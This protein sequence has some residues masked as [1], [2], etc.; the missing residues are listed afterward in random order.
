MDILENSLANGGGR[1]ER[2]FEGREVRRRGRE[3]FCDDLRAGCT[4]ITDFSF[5]ALRERRRDFF[6]LERL[7][8]F[9]AEAK[10]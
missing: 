6:E 9:I 7:L 3:D 2:D 8:L 10:N 4:T 5:R 1:A